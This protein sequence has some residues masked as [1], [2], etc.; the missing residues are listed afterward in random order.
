[1][2]RANSIWGAFAGIVLLSTGAL[3]QACINDRK[4][5]AVQVRILQ[6]EFMVASLTRRGSEYVSRYNAFASRFMPKLN[7]HGA[8]PC[9]YFA[10]EHGKAADARLV[11][12][13]DRE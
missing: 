8:V 12:H 6:T 3:A 10:R 5:E 1:M 11:R 13:P 7:E 9:R 2:G 4:R